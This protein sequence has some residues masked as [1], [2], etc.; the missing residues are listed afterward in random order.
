MI[1][2][3]KCNN[4]GLEFKADDTLLV[5]CPECQSDNVSTMQ[6][7]KPILK[8]ALIAL[9]ALLVAA[10]IALVVKSVKSDTGAGEPVPDEPIIIDPDPIPEEDI[11]TPDSDY[12]EIEPIT[13]LF[14]KGD[15]KTEKYSF[16]VQT[17]A[18][19]TLKY[20]LT[21]HKTG[22]KTEYAAPGGNFVNVPPAG[23]GTYILTIEQYD[24]NK[25]TDKGEREMPG[26][27]P[28]V[29]AV[30]KLTTG[31]V[32]QYVNT[33]VANNGTGLQKINASGMF[34]KGVK[35]IIEGKTCY[36]DDLDM[37]ML[38]SGCNSAIV[39]S[40]GYDNMNRVNRINLRFQ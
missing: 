39:E 30:K 28:F 21:D 10:G 6:V 33:F 37:E 8:Y 40:V 11:T 20:Y 18:T 35:L 2:Q 29:K 38:I 26:F 36:W 17:A 13:V 24:G 19:G 14:L 22:K 32:Q 31:E 3:Y 4:C 5:T 1:R 12:K 15:P 7:K 25:L 34:A 16:T 9:G 27:D 23:D